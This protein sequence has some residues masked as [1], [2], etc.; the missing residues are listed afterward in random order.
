ML[1]PGSRGA[2]ATSTERAG[3]GRRASNSDD[4]D[5]NDTKDNNNDDDN[6]DNDNDRN[7]V[8]THVQNAIYIYIHTYL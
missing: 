2:V 6:N 4:N 1:V 7:I 8:I 3:P 5:S